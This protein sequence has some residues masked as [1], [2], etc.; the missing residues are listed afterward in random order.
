M[1]DVRT[2]MVSCRFVFTVLASL[3]LPFGI[4]PT[5]GSVTTRVSKA[6]DG[7]PGNLD[8]YSA[9]VSP[10]RDFVAFASHADNLVDDDNNWWADIFVHD[11]SWWDAVGVMRTMRVSVPSG[12]VGEAD[13]WSQEPSISRFG[14]LTAFCSGATNLVPDILGWDDIFVHDRRTR[15]TVRVSVSSAGTSGDG[16]SFS[17]SISADGCCVAFV[18]YATNLVTPDTNGYCDIFVHELGTGVTT[19]VS[20]SSTGAPGDG[21]S[22]YPSIS[23]D[24]RYVAFESEATTLVGDDT[25]GFSDVFVH[26]R[27]TGETTRVSLSTDGE[28]GDAESLSASI[29]SREGSRYVAFGSLATNLVEDDTNG[30]SDVFVRDR[31][32]GQTTRVS[33]SSAEEQGNSFSGHP[34]ISADGR[35]VTFTSWAW[36]L[37]P[38][39]TGQWGDVFVRDRDTGETVRVSSSPMGQ[40]GNGSSIASS[41]AGGN[42]FAVAFES[43]ASN[44]IGHDVNGCC[45]AFL[46]TA[47]ANTYPNIDEF[48]AD[49]GSTIEDPDEP[50]EFASWIELYNPGTEPIDLG[51]MY[52]TNE[53]DDPTRYEIPAGV[54][55]PAGGHLLFWADKDDAQGPT[56][57]N[58]KLKTSG[59]EIGLYD[60]NSNGY[61]ALGTLHY[62]A[63]STD[64][65]TGRFPDG[66]DCWRTFTNP[67]PGASNGTLC[68]V[69]G[70]DDVDLA[71]FSVFCGCITG[72]SGGS[73]V[74]GCEAFDSDCDGDVDLVDFAGFQKAHES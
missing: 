28:E 73:P 11:R 26:D 54:S 29:S 21:D 32:T 53:L 8:S 70:D 55:I 47:W 3:S 56:H 69:D 42:G 31:Q 37:V 52:L 51:G 74:S 68:D 46:Y 9:S 34:A 48:M 50:G 15:V 72:P 2:R 59:G 16:N 33:V 30:W 71:D 45:D 62:E 41:I 64:V 4:Q 17:P 36:N 49:N 1:K 13:W 18:S 22:F 58:F 24:G 66:A 67:T 38:D 44:L 19:R 43:E 27:E 65:S 7:E 40:E 6:S 23:A 10:S 39:D 60:T 35:Y 14:R 12:G 57:T 20:V 61:T 25:N 5:E 63:Q